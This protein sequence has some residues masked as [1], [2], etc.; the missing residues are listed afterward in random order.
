MLGSGPLSSIRGKHVF[1][2]SLKAFVKNCWTSTSE[3]YLSLKRVPYNVLS[4]AHCLQ[5][6]ECLLLRPEL[7]FIIPCPTH[8]FLQVVFDRFNPQ[9]PK[10]HSNVSYRNEVHFPRFFRVDRKIISISSIISLYLLRP[11]YA[12]SPRIELNRPVE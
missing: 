1:G 10:A 11:R 8:P 5:R 12:A 7:E 2:I 4:L 3:R 6:G 9:I